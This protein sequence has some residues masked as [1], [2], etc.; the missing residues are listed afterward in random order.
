MFSRT[1]RSNWL[2]GALA[3]F[4]VALAMSPAAQAVLERN[5]PVSNAPSV[6]GYPA[7][8]QDTT[9]LALEFC[10][11]RNQAE[12]AGG[13]CLLL[14]GDVPVAPEVF[15]TQFAG[16]H[17][18]FAANTSTSL[19]SGGQA[20][21]VLALEAAFTAEVAPGAQIAFS[22]IRVK[23]DP[24][25]ATGTYR[26]IHPYGEEL[27]NAVQ[28]DRIFF[29]DDVGIN[30]PPGNFD[31]A[32][33]SRIG[34]FLLP[35]TTPGGAEL[36]AVAGPVP[37]KLYIADPARIGPVTGSALANFTDS[38]GAARNH[39]IFRVEGPRGS[40]LGGQ[41]VDFVE[42]ANFNLM[43]RIFTGM[44]PSRVDV[45]RVNYTRNATGQKLDVFATGFPTVQ[46][47]LPGQTPPPAAW[48]ALSFFDAPCTGTLDTLTGDILPPFGAPIGASEVQMINS[49]TDF[50]GQS[51]PT[52]I[53]SVVCVKDA[54]ARDT[55]GNTVPAYFP[56]RVTDQVTISEALYDPNTRSISVRASSS[57]QVSP[58]SLTIPELGALSGGLITVSPLA[59]P[60][61]IVRVLS[62]RGGSDEKKVTTGF[63][64][65][66]APGAPLAVNDS[67]TF[68]EDSPPQ[69]IKLLSNDT[70]VAGGTV[71][72]ASLPRLGT[73]VLNADGTVTY[74]P[75][76]NANGLDSFTY[77]VTAGTVATNRANVSINITP[78]ND[79]PVAVNDTLSTFVNQATT[80]D[81]LAND[82][83]PD[84][85]TD[86][87]AVAGLTAPT[88]AGA[89]V[90]AAGATATFSA[91]QPGTYTFNYQA[92][93]AAGTTSNVA[94]VTVNAAASQTINVTRAQYTR[95]SARLRID[96]TVSPVTTPPQ[97]LELRWANGSNTTSLVATAVPDATGLWTIDLR[98]VTGI[99]NPDN[100]KANQGVV[101][102]PG[103][104][105]QVTTP[106]QIRQ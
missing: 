19:A 49:D 14:A 3:A 4:L 52:A 28:G 17:F 37:G 62:S 33:D 77:I 88:P 5:G 44:L 8:Y 21:L 99:Q 38:T 53:P 26:F 10:D 2:A 102:I 16:E 79:P 95:S 63:A 87:V 13:W 20:M 11:P 1:I 30:C 15:P 78:V 22:R 70:N 31:C 9:G 72:L 71:S 106:I 103:S 105:A 80:L 67:V 54:S 18:W 92:Q 42:T 84:G 83:D 55:T 7:W 48:P 86:L 68:P 34:P 93:D 76:P 100:S 46:G 27:I 58:P 60:P 6:G 82:T 45:K 56:K 81:L 12:V 85:Q 23:L 43:G 90:T 96:G 104:A 101:T 69:T 66:P 35:S 98:G 39:N 29:T 74:T 36:P 32:M 59:V 41:G 89:A 97:R 50:W 61:D 40:N 91:S 47:R 24:V 94:T 73:A 51:Q 57:D 25:P 75:N 65:G 64:S